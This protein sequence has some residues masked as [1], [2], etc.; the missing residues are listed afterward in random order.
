MAN[1]ELLPIWKKGATT[2]ERLHELALLAEKKPELFDKWVLVY[3]EDNDQRFRIR[4]EQGENT[5]TSDCFAVLSAG[6]MHIFEH[7]RKEQL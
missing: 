2:A 3:C 1:V 5:R 6:A 4:Y 7:T